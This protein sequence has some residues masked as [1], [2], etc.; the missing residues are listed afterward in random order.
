MS[1]TYLYVSVVDIV[2]GGGLAGVVNNA[3]NISGGMG[4]AATQAGKN[5]GGARGYWAGGATSLKISLWRAS[6]G[7]RVAN[8]TIAV[9]GAGLWTA[10]FTTPF[11]LVAG[12]AY[13]ITM[14]D[15]SG[16]HYTS[17]NGATTGTAPMADVMPAGLSGGPAMIGPGIEVTYY[18]SNSGDGRYGIAQ[19]GDINPNGALSGVWYPVEPIVY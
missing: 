5:C 7:A 18:A 13:G 14:W 11:A 4:F 15:T 2:M 3:G 8:T 16:D 17:Y 19:S 6:D 12:Q 1:T 10:T 9:S